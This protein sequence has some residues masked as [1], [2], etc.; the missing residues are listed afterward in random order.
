MK[1]SVKKK[2]KVQ[3]DLKI[4]EKFHT[5]WNSYFL[6][7]PKRIEYSKSEFLGINKKSRKIIRITYKILKKSLNKIIKDFDLKIINLLRKE[8]NFDL[9]HFANYIGRTNTPFVADYEGVALLSGGGNEKKREYYEKGLLQKNLKCLLPMNKE[10]LKSFNLYFKNF[11][12]DIKQ[13]VVYPLPFIPK[14]FKKKV[15][16]ENIVLF[17]G[18]SNLLNQIGIYN[19]GSF[20]VLLAF[21]EI[22]K[23]YP[24]WKFIFLGKT[25]LEISIKSKENLIIKDPI[26]QEKLWELMNKSKIF[27]QACYITPAMSFLEVMNFKLPIITYDSNA[28]K[29]YV[30]SKN[31]IL[32]KPE[33]VNIFNKF[34]RGV[35][36]E[37]QMKRIRKNSEKNSIKIMKAIEK[38]LNNESLIKKLG[39]NGLKRVINGKFSIEKRNK[40]LEEIY[41]KALE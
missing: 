32:I 20:E 35:I 19:K 27:V 5:L 17:A 2:I 26:P 23:K 33:E 25:P 8:K 36:N 4:S 14:K 41:L 29:E 21:K 15:Q 13:E 16:K 11:N 30:D 22:S 34:N 37:N 40:K 9:I 18:S 10:A 1:K 3:L 28:N 24:Y 38:L 12:L 31:G 39:E 6:M 7:P